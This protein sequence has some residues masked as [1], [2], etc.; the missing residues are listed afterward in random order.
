MPF[1]NGITENT[2]FNNRLQPC[3]IF[4]GSLL[5]LKFRY[6]ASENSANCDVTSS[7][8]N[9]NVL[10][11]AKMRGGFSVTQEFA[12][13]AVNRLDLASEDSTTWSHDYTCDPFGNRG[14]AGSSLSFSA[15]TNRITGAGYDPAGNLTSLANF[16]DSMVY[17]ANNKMTSFAD[18]SGD[19]LRT[20]TY[21]YDGQGARVQRTSRTGSDSE[22]TTTY[23]Y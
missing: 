10:E 7:D 19:L 5:T 14:L 21:V 11:Q 16:T 13:D 6:G 8:N 20:G 1:G 23:V 4:A 9:G 18:G 22:V 15:S 2:T 12:Y 17:D 3:R